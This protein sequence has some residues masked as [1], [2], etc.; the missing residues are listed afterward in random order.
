MIVHG[1]DLVS[2]GKFEKMIGSKR[3]LDR[4]FTANE[5]LHCN[6]SAERYAA[7]FAAKE[8]LLKALGLGIVE[9]VSLK[10][11]EVVFKP[12]GSPDL[13]LCGAVAAAAE[14]SGIE[15]WSLSF[16]HSAGFAVASVI[17]FASGSGR[18]TTDPG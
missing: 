1:I 8:A 6:G 17:G 3:Y 7:R 14:E 4:C 9:G 12:S 11:V 10:D 13:K 18:S 2:V 15:S 5:Q 16:A